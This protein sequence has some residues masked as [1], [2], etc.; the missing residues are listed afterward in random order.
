MSKNELFEDFSLGLEKTKVLISSKS[1]KR[2][3]NFDHT[4]QYIIESFLKNGNLDDYKLTSETSCNCVPKENLIRKEEFSCLED[5]E[6]ITSHVQRYE[7]NKN[8][9]C[10]LKSHTCDNR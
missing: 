8:C 9:S 2:L 5:C 3:K 10:V 4:K 1:K 7:C 6:C